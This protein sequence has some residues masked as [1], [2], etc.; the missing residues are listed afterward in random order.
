VV[1]LVDDQQVEEPGLVGGRGED[2]VE[3][4][5][6]ARGAQP[7]H[8]DDGAG[9][10]AERVGFEPVGAAQL[11][12]PAGVEHLEAQP[13]AISHLGRPLAGEGSR[14]HDDHPAGPVAQQQLLDDEAGLDGLSESQVQ[15]VPAEVCDTCGERYFDVPV[16]RQLTGLVRQAAAA[17]VVIDVRRYATAA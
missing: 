12:Q 5:L 17:G 14:A 3:E 10:D 15:D 8:G 4:A 1:G 11:L 2:L 7:L 13:E 9:K 6:D 16:V